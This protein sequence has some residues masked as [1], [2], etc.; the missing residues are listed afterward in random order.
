MTPNKTFYI[1]TYGCQMNEYDS[2]I[3]SAIL[4]SGGYI[5]AESPATA[6]MVFLNTCSVRDHA[7]Q[8]IHSRLGELYKFKKKRPDML[9]G[10]VGC[11]AQNMKTKLLKSKPYVNI[12]LGPDSYRH[13]LDHLE[14]E[15]LHIVD[16]KLSKFEVYDQLFPARKE[17]INAWISIMRGCDKFCSYCI[18]PYTR[19]RERSRSIDSIVEEAK[20]CVDQGFVEIT[21]LGQNV[22]SFDYEGSR[23][24]KLL[25]E[26]VKIK[27]L[28]R[29]RYT[30]PHPQDVDD[31]LIQLHA[32]YKD[33]IATHI[34]LPLQ[35][36]SN[37]VLKA[38]NRTYTRE[39]YLELVNKIHSKVPEI[40]LTTDIIVGFPGE[41]DADFRDT[42]DIM[43][44]VKYSSAYTFKYS[45]R[46]YTKA[47]KMEDSVSEAEKSARL[48]ELIELQKKHTLFRFREL[49]GKEVKILVE[50]ESKKD[51]NEWMGRTSCNKIVVFSK[52]GEAPRDMV[53][54]KITDA[55][56]ITL[57]SR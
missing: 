18:V 1:E 33:V 14:S 11:M 24:D 22:N 54:R 27:G 51:P 10:V 4:Q 9:I 56:G 5:P 36:G 49:I 44:Q 43:K 30:S 26:L 50:H 41:T 57:F 35:A 8:K 28:K 29:L 34:H 6:D 12:I 21:L 47:F 31:N 52:M 46:P 45:P 15:K 48:T 19:G 25:K 16:T 20:R 38:M 55:H 37:A 3:L 39:H 23:F 17:G 13:I 7:E 2:E 32:D 42:L 53:T 40:G